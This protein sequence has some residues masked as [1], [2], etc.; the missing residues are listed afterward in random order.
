[1]GKTV[2]VAAGAQIVVFGAVVVSEGQID[3]AVVGQQIVVAVVV[4][5]QI[6]VAVVEEQIVVAI[7]KIAFV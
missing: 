2:S 5:E 1:V 7:E 4:G 3:V 6:V